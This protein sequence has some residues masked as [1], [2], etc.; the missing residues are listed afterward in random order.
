MKNEDIIFNK[1][2]NAALSKEV[3]SFD[4]MDAVWDRIEQKLE[5]NHAKKQ[6]QTW[7]K[8]AVAAVIVLCTGTGFLVLN[9]SKSNILPAKV[10]QNVVVETKID[11]AVVVDKQNVLIKKNA[12]TILKK[13]LEKPAANNAVAQE[14]TINE[15]ASQNEAM[16]PL[17]KMSARNMTVPD[18]AL[19]QVNKQKI[20]YQN[21]DLVTKEEVSSRVKFFESVG[22]KSNLRSSYAP[23]QDKVA[24]EKKK[25][26]LVVIDGE[27][28]RK[29]GKLQNISPNDVVDI[30]VLK[31]P[32]Y[33]I[34][35]EAFSEESLFG[36][37]PT[38]PYAPLNEQEIETIEIFQ[39]K[40]AIEKFG[41]KGK[42]GVVVIKTKNG[43]PKE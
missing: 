40:N 13:M 30:E 16:S 25:E 22:V 10:Q 33:I 12:N 19:Y 15:T 6:S 29:K 21:V 27:V 11:T 5:T 36:S 38:S 3:P 9:T 2:K 32:L 24:Q 39:N 7:K 42:M 41:K 26:P 31:N 14:K 28:L 34:N 43:K 18:T 1:I 20:S 17:E 35:G 37:N 23:A 4:N 8:I